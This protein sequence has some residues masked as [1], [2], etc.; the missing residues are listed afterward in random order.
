[1]RRLPTR[2][3]LFALLVTASPPGATLADQSPADAVA[4]EIHGR[5]VASHVRF[6]ASD[7]LEG[8]EAGARGERITARYLADFYWGL[9]LGPAGPNGSWE[10]RFDLHQ[11][12]LGEGNRLAVVRRGP[13]SDATTHY[14]IDSDFVPFNVSGSGA[15]SAPVVFAGYGIV[16]PEHGWND[17]AGIDPR[18]AVVLLLRHEPRENDPDAVFGGLAMTKHASF[19]AKI[20]LAQ[21]KGAAAVLLVTDPLAHDSDARDPGNSLARWSELSQRDEHDSRPPADPVQLYPEIAPDVRIPALHISPRVA[22]DLLAGSGNTLE[23]LQRRLDE[24]GKAVSQRLPGVA[25]E[26]VAD[27]EIEAV[28]V[29]NV[30]AKLE[31]S[32][33]QLK[34]QVVVVGGHLDHVGHGHFGSTTGHWGAI[35]PGAD[36][37]ASGTATIL[38]IAE[39]FVEAGVRPKRTILFA[40]F[41][42]EEKGLMGSRWFVDHPTVPRE[43]I[44]AMLNLDMVGRNDPAVLSVNGDSRAAGLDALAKQLGAAMGVAINNDAGSGI[45][46][47]DQWSF[48]RVGIPAIAYFSGTHDDYHSPAD[49]PDKIVADKLQNVGRLVARTAW[50][51]AEH[52]VPAAP[53]T[54]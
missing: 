13:G 47:S 18:G 26:L 37:N 11:A 19:L 42:A 29:R 41:T 7:W 33:P 40:H 6:L 38:S 36:D 45:D 4:A 14:R 16:A 22:N 10:Q 5:R 39:A 48:A 17:Y 23:A 44:V 20:R 46:R 12:T 52:G 27:L 9:G 24:T 49:T 43:S 31:G 54:N 32:D 28:P 1:M 50:E 21:A 34:H 51:L 2:S 8:R 15:A 25:V 3:L 35:H 30:L 53:E